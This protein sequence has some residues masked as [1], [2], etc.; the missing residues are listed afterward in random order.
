[1]TSQVFGV[2]WKGLRE[3]KTEVRNKKQE[4][5]LGRMPGY[6]NEKSTSQQGDG[7][8]VQRRLFYAGEKSRELS[9]F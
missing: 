5:C 8:G 7:S 2:R 3:E 4:L 6:P 9:V 1:M